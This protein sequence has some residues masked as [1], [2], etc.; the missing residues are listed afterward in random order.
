MKNHKE[1]INNYE[2]LVEAEFKYCCFKQGCRRVG[3]NCIGCSGERNAILHYGHPGEPNE[4]IVEDGSLRLIDMGCE[5]HGYTADITC[6]FPSNGKFTQEQ[7][8]IYTAVWN[9]VQEIEKRLKPGVD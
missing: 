7:K 6:T 2:F 9:A 5:Y 4:K 1:S 8:D 3:Y